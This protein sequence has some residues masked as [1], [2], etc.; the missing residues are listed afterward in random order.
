MDTFDITI[1]FVGVYGKDED[2]AIERLGV[3]LEDAEVY[4]DR[5]DIDWLL[6]GIEKV[7]ERG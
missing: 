1:T 7:E 2:D 4:N 3:A 5:G 6:E